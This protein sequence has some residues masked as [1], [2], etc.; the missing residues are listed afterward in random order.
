MVR[1]ATLFVLAALLAAGCA[2]PAPP[3]RPTGHQ[4]LTPDQRLELL[5]IVTP[6]EWPRRQVS[7]SSFEIA[8]STGTEAD[9]HPTAGEKNSPPVELI[10]TVSDRRP[11]TDTSALLK[12]DTL[13]RLSYEVVDFYGRKVAGDTPGF[14]SVPQGS[15]AECKV[16]LAGLTQAGYY[17][18]TAHLTW[19]D[20]P[21]KSELTAR[22]GFA[23]IDPTIDA[24][25]ARWSPDRAEANQGTATLPPEPDNASPQL[26]D[27]ALVRRAVSVLAAGGNLDLPATTTHDPACCA[28]LAPLYA[29]LDQARAATAVW[30][31]LPL[32]KSPVFAS[33]DRAVAVLWTEAPGD[34]AGGTAE[35]GLLTIPD[36]DTLEAFDCQGQPIGLW[37]GRALLLPLGEAPIYVTSRVLG[38]A[39]LAAKLAPA[40]MKN[41]TPL[42][43]RILPITTPVGP[44]ATVTLEL[45]AL[46]SGGTDVTVETVGPE[47][48]TAADA[49][50]KVHVDPEHPARLAVRFNK[51]VRRVENSYPFLVRLKTADWKDERVLVAQE[52]VAIPAAK[53]SAGL[54]K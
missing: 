9:V 26:R 15:A 28:V 31:R 25:F 46:T 12:T 34:A 13:T 2:P 43:V 18:V 41:F 30:P 16:A 37:R 35:R 44:Q 49:P 36:A 3:P 42:A 40:A 47:G 45:V 10:F 53:G 4:A 14:V 52:A 54:G 51:A 24:T 8:I 22:Q 17:E 38:A 48:W 5:R 7:K 33:K 29:L 11:A 21:D 1:A 32:I 39:A 20:K 19:G 23:I 50:Q 27:W 6:V